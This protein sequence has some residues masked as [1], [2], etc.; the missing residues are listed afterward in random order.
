M[1]RLAVTSSVS[2]CD[3]RGRRLNS[4]QNDLVVNAYQQAGVLTMKPLLQL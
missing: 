1:V 4:E 2:V 3:L